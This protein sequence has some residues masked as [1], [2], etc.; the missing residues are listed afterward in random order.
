MDKE[1]SLPIPRP[2]SDVLQAVY[3]QAVQIGMAVTS[4][5]DDVVYDLYE[6]MYVWKGGP[7]C[8]DD[9]RLVL[10]HVSPDAELHD[11]LVEQLRTSG[12]AVTAHSLAGLH[13][14]YAGLPDWKR[15]E[16]ICSDTACIRSMQTS[17]QWNMRE[18][19]RNM[20]AW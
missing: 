12:I 2:H 16:R 7:L 10:R 19:L 6:R 13:A 1:C 3:E 8:V 20:I 18:L 14:L 4:P 15:M 17:H 11:L 5:T 9:V